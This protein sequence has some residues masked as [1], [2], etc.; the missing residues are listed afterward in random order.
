MPPDD[1]TEDPA[2]PP[3]M[4]PEAPETGGEPDGDGM[5][6]GLLCV[7]LEALGQ[8]DE[9]DQVNTPEVGDKGQ[10]SIE[11]SVAK[12]E[13]P[14]AYLKLDAINGKT[15]EEPQGPPTD[16]AEQAQLSQMAAQQPP[17]Q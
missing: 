15:I 17:P 8:P 16:D 4:P 11:Y 12:I 13:G 10:A 2:A 7:P 6:P 3:D 9:H 5:A 14:N 1:E